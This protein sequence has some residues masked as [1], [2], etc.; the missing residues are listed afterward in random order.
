M[1]ERISALKSR[2]AQTP[3]FERTAAALRG[4]E[5]VVWDGCVGSSFAFLGATAAERL[6]KTL[7]VVVAKVGNVESVAADLALF[8][9]APILKYPL[10]PTATLENS[11]EVFLSE[12]ADFGARVRVLKAL[13]RRAAGDFGAND[14]APIVVASLAALLQP[15]PT[16][17]QISDETIFLR[18]NEEF[19]RDKLLR[20]LSEGGFHSTTAVELPGEYSARGHIVDVFAVDWDKPVRIEFF[21]D[22]IESMRT[23]ETVDQRSL[24]ELASVEISRLRTRGE[25]TGAFVD[26]LPNDALTLMLETD[27][28]IGET[29]R[30]VAESSPDAERAGGR[31]VADVVNALYRFPTLHAVAVASGTEYAGTVVRADFGSVER[32]QG[33]LTQVEEAF[34]RSPSGEEIT[35]VCA[36]EAEARRLQETFRATKPIREKRLFFPVGALS[37]GF[38]W[39]VCGEFDDGENV[40]FIGAEQLFGRSIARRSSSKKKLSKVVDSFLELQEGDLVIH[41]DRGLARY[42]GVQTIEKANQREDHLKLEFADSAY[43]YVPASKIGKI[44][45]YVG[46]GTGRV[47]PKLAKLNGTAW[48]KQKKGV[49][50]AVLELASE[51]LELQAA[52]DSL[53]GVAFPPDGDWQKDFESLFPYRETEDQLA[54]IEAIKADMERPR[55]MDRLLCGDVGFGKTEVALRAAFKAV[56]AGYQVAVL[57]PTTVLTE[58]HYRTFCDR[59]STFPIRVAS[60]SRFSTKKEQA[61]TL[62]KMRTGEVDIVVG[63]HRLAQKDVEF[64]KL[65]LVVIDEEQKFGVKDKE[66]LKKYRNLVDVLTM[67]ATPIPRTLHFSLLGI[68]DVSKLETPP[69][70]RLPVETKV[71]RFNADVIRK[72]ILRELNR[73]GQVYFLH[74]RVYDIEELAT[75]IRNIVP[76]ARVRVG[77]AQMTPG[78]LE[79]TMRDF[80]LRRFDVLVCTTIVES[81]LDIPNANT[82]FIDGANRF[83]LAELHQLRGRVGR[84]KKQAYCY[85]LLDANQALTPDATRR[86][87][88]IEEYAR[89]GSGFQIAMKDLEIRG[90]GNI[91]GTRQSGHIATVGY[92]MYCDFLDAA[93]RALKSE[94][95]KLKVDVEIDLPGSAILPDEYVPDS[96]MKIDFYRRFNR[97]SKIE[98]AVE[99]RNELRDRFGPLPPEAERLFILTQIRIAAFAYRVRTIQLSQIDG[100]IGSGKMIA[101]TFRAPDLMYK[102]RSDLAKI[103]RTMRFVDSEREA[104]KGYVDMPRDLFDRDGTP[105]PDETLEFVRELFESASVQDDAGAEAVRNAELHRADKRRADAKKSTKAEIGKGAASASSKRGGGSPLGGAVRR[106]K[107]RGEK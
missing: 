54:A 80:V 44:Q 86:L 69:A 104:M 88:A 100:L 30:L 16:R 81:G 52:R 3:D 91:L 76:E 5:S 103:G 95:Q 38:D 18:Q 53:E 106:V 71:L 17:D 73:G 75:K 64:K 47:Q 107:K 46:A 50:E 27:T 28:I 42:L 55:P 59:T 1:N 58:Q 36:S 70:D 4:G 62:E 85:L 99:I 90:A 98:E 68:R 37:N 51:M 9:D 2:L 19:G 45:K 26:R 11:D 24:E 14:P 67:T 40:V 21:G 79:E 35:V 101:I 66:Q 25:A 56:E 61:E 29:T 105:R 34:N 94:P 48:A 92:E 23:F 6:R 77:H 82:I 43:L 8:T 102:L 89:L 7:L 20:W 13:D 74:N 41:V 22:E 39:K 57:A 32:F 83:G 49:Q 10:L 63:T 84:E 72:T 33:E 87:K 60:L 31:T 78:A 97:V 12:D 65:G 93:V 15:V 96:R